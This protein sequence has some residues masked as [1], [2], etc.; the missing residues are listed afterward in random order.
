MLFNNIFSSHYARALVLFLFYYVCSA[1]CPR[2]NVD[3]PV[4]KINSSLL[5]K[6]HFPPASNRIDLVLKK[7]PF[8]ITDTVPTPLPPLSPPSLP[9]TLMRTYTQNSLYTQLP[10]ASMS[11]RHDDVMISSLGYPL[12]LNKWQSRG[13]SIIIATTFRLITIPSL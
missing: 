7:G 4:R 12:L 9:R 2:H 11:S 5:R 1:C 6:V 3:G 8:R 13:A 10:R